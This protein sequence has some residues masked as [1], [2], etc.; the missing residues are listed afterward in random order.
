MFVEMAGVEDVVADQVTRKV[1]V[2]GT[3]RP[4]HVLSSARQ[5]KPQSKYWSDY[6]GY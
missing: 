3:M 5:D 6:H 1:V 2:V 4:E